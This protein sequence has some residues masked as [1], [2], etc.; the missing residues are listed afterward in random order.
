[1]SSSKRKENEAGSLDPSRRL[2]LQDCGGMLPRRDRR[3]GCE[4]QDQ[5]NARRIT[6][7]QR[8]R[9]AARIWAQ[10]RGSA[11]DGAPSPQSRSDSV[12][13]PCATPTGVESLSDFLKSWCLKSLCDHEQMVT[14]LLFRARSST[15][16]TIVVEERRLVGECHVDESCSVTVTGYRGGGLS[17]GLVGDPEH[18]ALAQVD[19]LGTPFGHWRPPNHDP[20]SAY[21]ASSPRDQL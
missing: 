10:A 4:T 20:G 16:I 1:M 3:H 14:S 2:L 18:R 21:R 8:H 9:P 6:H 13:V 17:R 7:R 12:E 19:V 11:V 5:E 15:T